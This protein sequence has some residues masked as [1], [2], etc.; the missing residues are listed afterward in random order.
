MLI[1]SL[2]YT[3]FYGSPCPITLWPLIGY[4]CGIKLTQ[5]APIVSPVGSGKEEVASHCEFLKC[6]LQYTLKI[7]NGRRFG[8]VESK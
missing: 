6:T 1:C 2:P 3:D 8:K 4:I 5:R 7:R